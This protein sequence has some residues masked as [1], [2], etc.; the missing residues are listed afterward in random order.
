M[1]SGFLIN[2]GDSMQDIYSKLTK[3][4]LMLAD[5]INKGSIVA[6]I[7]TD[8]AYLLIYL[9]YIGKCDRAFGSD[10][11]IGPL[12][13]ALFNVR[14]FGMQDKITLTLCNG[15]DDKTQ[16]TAD[17]FV[18]A[19]MG[20]ELMSE[21]INKSSVL[22]EGNPTL[23]LQPM[24]GEEELREYLY[25]NGYKITDEDL[26][27]EGHRYYTMMTVTKG[28]EQHISD[29]YSYVG[30]NLIKNRHPLLMEFINYNIKRLSR[31]IEGMRSASDPNIIEIKRLSNIKSELEKIDLD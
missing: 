25:K 26:C 21:I 29:I 18:I 9:V 12:E 17:T 27:K 15:I 20:G 10:V 28:K 31:A 5:K 1:K 13:R 7:G 3:R 16:K 24:S 30:Y 6:D 19:G 2:Q 23:L 22:K 8:H 11:R 4:L 14:D